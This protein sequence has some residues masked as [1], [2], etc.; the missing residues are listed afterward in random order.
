MYLLIIAVVLLIMKWQ[1]IGPVA[2]LSWWWIAVPFGLTIAWWAWA[3]ST[4]Y[5]QRQAMKKMDEK[6]E[7]RRT[8]AMS[9]LGLQDPKR[10]RR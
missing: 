5:T 8:K 2:D 1:A 3:D 7:A 4:G 9:A 6:R 10:R